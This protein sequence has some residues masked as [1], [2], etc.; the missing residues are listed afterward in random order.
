[1]FKFDILFSISGVLNTNG[2]LW[3]DHKRFTL[4]TLKD[5]GMGKSVLQTKIQEEITECLSLM[6]ELKGTPFDP[7]EIITKNVSNI[8]N[9]L[10]F[11]AKFRRDDVEFKR[12]FELMDWY[13]ANLGVSNI[14][15]FIPWLKHLPGDIFKY[16]ES[17]RKS[18]EVFAFCRKV[19]EEHIKKI[20]SANINDFTS[21]YIKEFNNQ[22][23]DNLDST[24][25]LEQLSAIISDL[26]LA[27]TE[28]TTTTLRWSLALLACY[29]EIQ[30]RMF[31]EINE[32]IGTTKLPSVEDRMKLTYV[33]AFYKEVLRFCNLIPSTIPRTVTEDTELGGYIIPKQASRITT[34]FSQMKISGA[35][36]K[37]SDLIVF[38]NQMDN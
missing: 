19:I 8:I 37:H 24:F 2:V 15:Q 27:G 5:F 38:L 12:M 18:D 20:D 16:K 33:E 22:K 32:R 4:S 29:P 26:F 7:K 11:G 23:Q 25:S 35:I 28:T 34:Q 17:I 13:V 3:R 21:A 6:E 36:Q 14:L 10:S 30:E 31:T 1:M 9:Y